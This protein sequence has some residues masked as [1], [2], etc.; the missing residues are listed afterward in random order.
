MPRGGDLR[1]ER[2]LPLGQRLRR[3]C[4]TFAP[5]R[6]PAGGHSVSPFPLHQRLKRDLRE[7][8]TKYESGQGRIMDWFTI[9]ALLITLGAGIGLSLLV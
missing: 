3:D 8:K 5:L 2:R 1:L 9:A 6:A 7:P 4:A